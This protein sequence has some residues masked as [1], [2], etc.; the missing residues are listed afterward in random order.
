MGCV[1]VDGAYSFQ[2][3][4][5]LFNVYRTAEGIDPEPVLRW[6]ASLYRATGFMGCRRIR[7]L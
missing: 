4:E 5:F 2:R 7:Y 3:D 1:A 6:L